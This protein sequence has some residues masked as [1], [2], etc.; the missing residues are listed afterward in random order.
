MDDVPDLLTAPPLQELAAGDC[1]FRGAGTAGPQEERPGAGTAK[2]VA[3]RLAD[4]HDIVIRAENG[5]VRA[6]PV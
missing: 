6:G 4:G 2:R 1:R 3:D 5:V